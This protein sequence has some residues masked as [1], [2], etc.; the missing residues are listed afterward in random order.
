MTKIIDKLLS[1]VA[2]YVLRQKVMKPGNWFHGVTIEE[3][4]KTVLVD[5]W[6]LEFVPEE[7]KTGRLCLFAV[8]DDGNALEHVPENLKTPEICLTAVKQAGG[9]LEY[10]PKHIKSPEI[11]VAAV[12]KA[13]HALAYVPFGLRTEKVCLAAVRPNSYGSLCRVGYNYLT[14]YKD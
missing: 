9:A 12:R 7:Y 13:D 4:V 8:R 14:P 1:V 5:G 2:N 11:C 10:V 3:M 6:V